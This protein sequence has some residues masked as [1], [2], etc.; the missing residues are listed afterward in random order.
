MI[1]AHTHRELLL[2]FKLPHE[3]QGE[4]FVFLDHMIIKQI[5]NLI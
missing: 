5:Q 1:A 4:S 2:L 3:V